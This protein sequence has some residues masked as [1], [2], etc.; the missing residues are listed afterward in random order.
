[1]IQWRHIPS[2]DREKVMKTL[3]LYMMIRI[4]TEPRVKTR[5]RSEARPMNRMPFWTTSW[6]RSDR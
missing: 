4:W 3:M 2:W 6:P 1:M 5:M